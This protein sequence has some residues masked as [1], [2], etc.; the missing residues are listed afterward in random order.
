[1]LT[2]VNDRVVSHVIPVVTPLELVCARII[3]ASLA[4]VICGCYRS[5]SAPNSFCTKLHEVVD[6]LWLR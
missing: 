5:P 4:F 3:L 2:A 6:R 1:M